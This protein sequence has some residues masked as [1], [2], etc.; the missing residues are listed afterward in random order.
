MFP[1]TLRCGKG[2]GSTFR[3]GAVDRRG[4]AC[5]G[6]PGGLLDGGVEDGVEPVKGG[7]EVQIVPKPVTE[8]EGVGADGLFSGEEGAEAVEFLVGYGEADHLLDCGTKMSGGLN[9]SWEN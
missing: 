2:G 5:R 9:M 8:N 4:G 3:P 6:Q 1:L 7:L